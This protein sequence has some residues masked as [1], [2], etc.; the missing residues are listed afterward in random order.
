MTIE[1]VLISFI[2]EIIRLLS[3]GVAYDNGLALDAEA[4]AYQEQEQ[5]QHQQRQQGLAAAA[6]RQPRASADRLH[7]C[8]A[9]PAPQYTLHEHIA[10]AV[11]TALCGGSTVQFIILIQNDKATAAE[12]SQMLCRYMTRHS[13]IPN[14]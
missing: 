11:S 5:Q 12:R 6:G 2:C 8:N 7:I 4:T 3:L 9:T 13:F 14:L 1:K 10:D